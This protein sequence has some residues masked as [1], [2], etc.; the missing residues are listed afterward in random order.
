[1]VSEKSQTEKATY[2]M[3][4]FIWNFRKDKSMQTESRLVV[5]RGWKE[6]EMGSEWYS[7]GYRFWGVEGDKN[8]LELGSFDGCTIL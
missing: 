3:S 1:M 5:A 2:Y 6:R 4:Q 7:D 8:I